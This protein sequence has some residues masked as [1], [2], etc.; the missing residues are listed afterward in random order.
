ME[1]YN[2]KNE[3]IYKDNVN[4]IGEIKRFVG[5]V[6]DKSNL[7]V[8]KNALI[9]VKPNL[10][11]DLNALTGNSTDLRVISA[12]LYHL[13]RKG[14]NNIIVADGPNCAIN[15][16]GINVIK[17]LCIDKLCDYYGVKYVNL[18][19]TDTKEV[20]LG[21]RKANVSRL[22]FDCDYL[23]NV[24]KIKTHFEAVMTISCKNFVG[25]LSK[26]N[27]RRVHDGDI[28]KN[29]VS[30]NELIRP[31]LN[32]VDGLIAMEG[33]GPA[34]GTPKNFG[35]IVA[36]KNP[37]LV[38]SFCAKLAGFNY[39]EVPYVKLA[40]DKGYIDNED[41]VKLDDIK[42]HVKLLRANKNILANIFL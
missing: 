28:I 16:A 5:S 13:K 42:T 8:S 20:V 7:P 37:F 11:N 38:D 32:I 39:D 23:I 25:C 26:L 2:F 6:L 31:D 27:K 12:I 15:H 41:I 10:N 30:L 36:G 34:A 17:R 29:L 3:V 19:Y 40:V 18:N 1:F 24:P 21:K 14:Y 4:G 22:C 35:V 33:D 9:F